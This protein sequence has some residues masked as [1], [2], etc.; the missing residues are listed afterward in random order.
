MTTMSWPMRA[1]LGF[2][3]AVI[4]TLVFHQGMWVALYGVGLMPRAPFPME[5]TG[6]WGV[7]KMVSLCFWGGLYGAV[8]GLV[9]P[10]LKAP[11]WLRGL[12][13]GII[14]ALVGCLLFCRSRASPS[15]TGSPGG[16]GCCPC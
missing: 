6:P 8:F 3:A 1:L 2:A 14:A 4:A 5:A 9:L 15:A 10:R 16:R 13:L 12:V 7:P 11:V